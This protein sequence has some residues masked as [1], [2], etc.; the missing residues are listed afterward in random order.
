MHIHN[1]HTYMYTYRRGRVCLGEALDV[2]E[3]GGR[4]WRDA[5]MK[6]L[7]PFAAARITNEEDHLVSPIR[8]LCVKKCPYIQCVF[9]CV[10]CLCAR[11][12]VCSKCV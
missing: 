12:C 7:G 3:Q 5:M 8:E 4:V 6:E 1:I 11:D 9:V 10:F 2:C